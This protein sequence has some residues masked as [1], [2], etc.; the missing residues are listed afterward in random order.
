MHH[1]IQPVTTG[2]SCS[3]RK[4]GVVTNPVGLVLAKLLI[5]KMELSLTTL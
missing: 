2:W 1:E 5:A 4:V 3:P